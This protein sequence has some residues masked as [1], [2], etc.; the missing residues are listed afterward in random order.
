MLYNLLAAAQYGGIWEFFPVIRIIMC[1]IIAICA[2]F[3]IAVIIIQPG[4]SSGIGA[5]N[6][7][8]E[9]F[10]SKNKGKT[11]ESKMKKLTVISSIILAV[12]CIVLV[13]LSAIAG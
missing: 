13:V 8:S 4:N 10:Y 11:F 12:C 6:G 3:D 7:Q 9:T 2:I 5:I 1:V